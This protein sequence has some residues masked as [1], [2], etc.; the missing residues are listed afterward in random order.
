[1]NCREEFRSLLLHVPLV[2]GRHRTGDAVLYGWSS[3]WK[4]SDSSAVLTAAICV[5]MSMQ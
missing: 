2:A 4:A 3:N 1:V 5:R